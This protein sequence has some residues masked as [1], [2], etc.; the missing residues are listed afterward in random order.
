M[1][2]HHKPYITHYV[3]YQEGKPHPHEISLFGRTLNEEERKRYY[4]ESSDEASHTEEKSKPNHNKCQHKKWTMSTKC[5][6]LNV[7]DDMKYRCNVSYKDLEKG[8]IIDSGASAHMTP[9]RSD[10]RNIYPVLRQVYMADGS[11]IICKEAGEITIP[12]RTSK[13]QTYNLKLKEVLIIPNLDRRLFSVNSFLNKGN[14]WV[15]FS[16]EHI[17]LGIRSGPKLRIPITSLQSSA[18][19]VTNPRKKYGKTSII[20]SPKTDNIKKRKI[21]LD[22]TLL[23]NIP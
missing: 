15:Q 4:G 7:N 6:A 13:S 20:N 14:N 21:P 19:M 3:K 17:E 2:K 11:S 10:C 16:P 12:I 23:K 18:M 22:L 5:R 9:H 8:W 1:Q